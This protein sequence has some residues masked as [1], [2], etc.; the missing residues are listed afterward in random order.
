MSLEYCTGEKCKFP[1][2]I[3]SQISL[4]SKSEGINSI[5]SIFNRENLSTSI[6]TF[7]E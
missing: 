7:C 5:S 4:G 1:L 6:S 3:S 2:R